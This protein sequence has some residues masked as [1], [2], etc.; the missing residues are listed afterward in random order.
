M[1]FKLLS[2]IHPTRR[3]EVSLINY[4]LFLDAISFIIILTDV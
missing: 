1:F 4:S 2:A 3:N